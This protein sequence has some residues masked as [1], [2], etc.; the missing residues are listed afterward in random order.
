MSTA[1]NIVVVVSRDGRVVH[2]PQHPETCGEYPWDWCW[3][4]EDR[5][6]WREAFIEA[7]MF[8]RPQADV[9]ISL[10]INEKLFDYR[11]W[12]DPAGDDLVVCRLT[13]CFPQ[14]L[15]AQERAVLS[16]VAGG[17]NNSEIAKALGI[18]SATVRSHIASTRRKLHV[19]RPEGLLLAALQMGYL[20]TEHGR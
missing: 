10:R 2:N 15:S 4:N 1:G 5:L 3:K 12:L 9:P 13:R 8:R 11:T 17:A 6:R 7:C 16:L 20:P 14:T 19:R 18:K